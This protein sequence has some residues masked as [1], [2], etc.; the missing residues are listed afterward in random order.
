METRTESDRNTQASGARMDASKIRSSPS[1]A[2]R[3]ARRRP[4]R[5]LTV[6]ASSN[7]AATNAIRPAAVRWPVRTR[8]AVPPHAAAAPPSS[9]A[10]DPMS[11]CRGRPTAG[12][13]LMVAAQY[14][15]GDRIPRPVRPGS[16]PPEKGSPQAV[17]YNRRPSARAAVRPPAGLPAREG[18]HMN[19]YEP[20]NIRNVALVGHSGA[21]K[22]TLIEGLLFTAGSINRMGKIEDGNTVSDFDPEE[23]RRGISVALSLAPLEWQDVKVNVLDGPGYADFIGDVR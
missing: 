3:R 6:P 20:R 12:E 2:N 5:A 13:P 22:T 9:E 4:A 1:S 17:S 7:S 23:V 11:S 18:S 16:A 21:G 8:A 14:H 19:V 15:H 10:A